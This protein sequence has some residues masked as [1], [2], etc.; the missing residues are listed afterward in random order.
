MRH[1]PKRL[2]IAAATAGLAVIGMLVASLLNNPGG[3]RA[4]VASARAVTGPTD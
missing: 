2:T 1:R 3:A 4:N